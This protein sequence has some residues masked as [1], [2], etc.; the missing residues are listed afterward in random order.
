MKTLLEINGLR[1]FHKNSQKVILRNIT[2]NVN[3]GEIIALVGASGS[4]KSL[5]AEALFHVLPENIGYSG[6]M[7]VENKEISPKLNGKEIV[8]IPQSVEALDPLMKIG[9]QLQIFS[10]ETNRINKVLEQLQLPS[11]I[12]NRYP[13]QLSGGQ[14]RRV[15]VASALISSASLIVADEPTPGLDE[16]ARSEMLHLLK[17]VRSAE[18]GMLM[19]THD[20]HAAMEA[21]DKIAVLHDGEII[22]LAV[23]TAFDKEG[24]RLRHPYTKAL[25]DALPE[26]KFSLPG[27]PVC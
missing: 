24:S 23:K 11:S 8:L 21:A 6:R 5:L 12:F 20:F 22:E 3:K 10:Q 26:N 16:Q 13:F 19:I 15:L 1:I 14:A 4:G 25:W 27:D 2:L 7:K 9:K 18:R 17:S